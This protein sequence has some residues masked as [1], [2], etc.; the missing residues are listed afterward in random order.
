[1]IVV[2]GAFGRTGR[3]VAHA[4]AQQPGQRLRLITR[5]PNQKSSGPDVEVARA[6]LTDANSLAQALSGARAA[7]LLLPDDL[8]AGPFHAERRAMA[9]GL[10][11]AVKQAGVSRL[12]LLSS[13]VASLG[14]HPEHGFAADLAYFERLV[15]DSGADVSVLRA[16]YFQDNLCA[17]LPAARADGRFLNFFASR[18]VALPTIAAADVGALAARALL[19]PSPARAEIVDLTGPHY[20][21]AEMALIVGSVIGRPISVEDVAAAQQEQLFRSWMSRE[22]ARAMVQ[23]LACLGSGRVVLRGARVEPGHTRLEQ[24]LRAALQDAEARP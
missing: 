11:R 14:E 7:Y 17:T 19:E 12:V 20:T 23:T 6:Q 8:R 13:L 16:A 2:F 9:E 4:L 10:A 24:V 5:N 15:L 3:V 21:P 1:M 18:D 22:A